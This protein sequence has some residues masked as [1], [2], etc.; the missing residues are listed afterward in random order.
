MYDI[1]CH[2]LPGIDDGSPSL[3]YSLNMARFAVEH[4]TTHM[5]V[6]PHIHPGRYDNEKQSIE[7]AYQAFKLALKTSNI[8]LKIGM[9]AEVR[10][11]AELLI[12]FDQHKIP[13]L[14][15]TDESV[16]MLLEM[17][18][19]QVPPGCEKLIDWLSERS[20]T[21]MIAHP[22]RNKAI[23]HNTDLLKPLIQRG[24]LL[25]ITA[26]SLVGQFG[27]SAQKIA[28]EILLDGNVEVI[29][30][31]SHNL[32]HRTPDISAGYQR[33]VEL[34]GEIEARKLVIDNPR[35]ITASQF[36]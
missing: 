27:E 2:L 8:P 11:S 28:E 26:G 18:H 1:H 35:R 31:D 14:G 17:P 5:V 15:K 21:A 36:E 30:S 34:V 16:F 32:T 13:F 23:M 10:V 9:A 19:D 22:E 33:A 24:C 25:Q 29:A 3:E 12:L 7:I 4:G 6:T 20:C